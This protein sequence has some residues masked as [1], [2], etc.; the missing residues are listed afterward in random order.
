MVVMR[1][2]LT[3]VMAR[4]VVIC[5]GVIFM[6]MSTMRMAVAVAVVCMAEG[7]HAHNVNDQSETA[8]GKQLSNLV[9]TIAFCQTLNGLVDNLNAYEPK[10]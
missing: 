6:V 8:Y 5:M 7:C 3:M 10:L 2:L 9:D 1:T 4:V